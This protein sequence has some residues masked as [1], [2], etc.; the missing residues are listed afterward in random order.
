MT[1]NLNSLLVAF[2]LALPAWANAQTRPPNIVFIL[3]D[4]VGYG[5]QANNLSPNLDALA[6]QGTSF[7]S[8]Y[9]API[10]TPSRSRLLLGRYEPRDGWG[11]VI[12]TESG[13]GI[14]NSITLAGKLHQQGYFTGIV[15]KWHLG[16][17]ENY[18]PE[19]HGF[20]SSFWIAASNEETPLE[21]RRRWDVVDPN[22][23]QNTLTQRFTQEAQAFIEAHKSEPFFLYLAETATHVPVVPN[24]AFV[25][26]SRLGTPYGDLYEELDWSVGQVMATLKAQGLDQNTLVIYASDNGATLKHGADGG[27]NLPLRGGKTGTNEGGIRVP[28]TVVWP[29]RIPAGRVVGAPAM[30][31][32]WF[33]TLVKIGGGKMLTPSRFDGA[34]IG[35][36][37]FGTGPRG[38]DARGNKNEFMFYSQYRLRAFRQGNF[39][40]IIDKKT[41]NPVRLYDLST[42]VGEALDLSK[43]QRAKM[44]AMGVRAKQIDAAL[45]RDHPAKM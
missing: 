4:D 22:P 9:A 24:P 6:A 27:V 21:I 23:P 36:L 25:G 40:I 43:T 44:L 38:R 12:H 33:P 42:D 32:D 41:G 2:V 7:T 17:L 8:Y 29:G 31:V 28:M 34:D 3:A 5:D 30:N 18:Q 26:T 35:P 11:D 37:M 20:D 39:K 1:W 13:D 16:N 19:L 10:C 14:D 45:P 15:G